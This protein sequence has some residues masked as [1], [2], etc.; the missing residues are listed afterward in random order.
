MGA[1]FLPYTTSDIL[2]NTT[3][4][5]YNKAPFEYSNCFTLYCTV[6]SVIMST[7]CSSS[8]VPHINSEWQHLFLNICPKID[9]LWRLDKYNLYYLLTSSY[10]TIIVMLKILK[11]CLRYKDAL[12]LYLS[13]VAHPAELIPVSATWN[14]TNN[15]TSL[16]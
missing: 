15:N 1:F 14:N 2:F 10:L 5:V 6:R 3:M 4:M 16:Y 7:Y 12:H 8:T 11:S 13:S 9:G